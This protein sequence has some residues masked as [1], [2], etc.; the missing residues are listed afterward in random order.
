MELQALE[1]TLIIYENFVKEN[2]KLSMEENESILSK[3]ETSGPEYFAA[4]YRLERQ[5]LIMH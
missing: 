1:A 3:H 2:F 5:R 4:I